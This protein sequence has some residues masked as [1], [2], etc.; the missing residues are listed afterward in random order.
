MAVMARND[1]VNIQKYEWDVP[2]E[3]AVTQFHNPYLAKTLSSAYNEGWL[4]IK[5]GIDM[6]VE[7]IR[8][9]ALTSQ[10][11]DRVLAK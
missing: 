4:G 2:C 11:L 6:F 8:L 1:L 3:F 10:E 9:D 5:N 7:D